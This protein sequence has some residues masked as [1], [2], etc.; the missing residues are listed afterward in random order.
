MV[1]N[2]ELAKRAESS[3]ASSSAPLQ[4]S[5]QIA[6][7]TAGSTTVLRHL[8]ASDKDDYEI[9]DFQ[10][11]AAKTVMLGSNL[12]AEHVHED[13]RATSVSPTRT[14]SNESFKSMKS[15]SSSVEP[16]P[17]Q[18]NLSAFVYVL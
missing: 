8:L 5:P 14:C 1:E 13:G 11:L 16:A 2:S 17:A 10:V 3:T 15:R 4:E 6:K 7:M 9:D 12:T 18:G